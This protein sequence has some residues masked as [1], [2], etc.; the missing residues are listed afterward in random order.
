M[1]GPAFGRELT[2]GVE[3][4]LFLVDASTLEPAPAVHAVVPDPGE[5]LKTELFQ[6]LLETTTPVCA[7]AP[8]ALDALQRLREEA[9]ERADAEGLAILAAGTHPLALGGEQPLVDAPVYRKLAAELGDGV[10]RQLVCGLHVHVGLPDERACLHAYEAVLP[11]LP[12]LLG[13]SASSPYLEGEEA[14]ALS[15]RAGR[16]A[17]LPGGSVPPPLPSWER[18]EELR[19]GGAGRTWWD[20]R[21]SPAFGTLELRIAD[22][23]TDVR[24]AAGVAALCQALVAAV[25]ERD[26]GEPVDRDAYVRRREEAARTPPALEPLADLVERPARGLGGWRLVEELLAG[27]SEAGCQLAL[28]RRDGLAAVVADLRDRSQP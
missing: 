24:R 11:W 12:A 22:M 6:C 16:I 1:D 8:E 19:A 28:G 13:L 2:I 4:E 9:A 15:G 23:Q 14:G 18:F 21:P 25:L 27:P 20:V 7:S 17:E 26:A 10:E 5:R 3:E